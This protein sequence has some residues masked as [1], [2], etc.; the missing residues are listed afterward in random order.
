MNGYF[1]VKSVAAAV[2]G[3][4]VWLIIA[5]GTLVIYGTWA[6][7]RWQ[8]HPP[9]FGGQSSR[10]LGILLI[11]IALPLLLEAFGRFAIH[12]RGTPA[13]VLPPEQ[14]VVQGFYRNVRNPMYVAVVSLILGQA[15]FFGD[16]RLL[17]YA[18]VVWL[19]FHLFV[20]LYEEPT[21]RRRY[22]SQYERYCAAVGR[23]IPRF[24][25]WTGS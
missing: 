3:S 18:L 15:L 6:I 4:F 23:W 14:L 20:V 1:C 2:R 17:V 24:K 21:L 13:P 7:S 8:L 10:G 11:L 22:G 9:L 25:P 12:G 5:P 19:V 16:A